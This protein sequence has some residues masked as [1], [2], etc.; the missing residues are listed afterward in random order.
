MEIRQELR[1]FIQE[2]FM[3][4]SGTTEL[5]DTESLLDLGIIDSTGILELVEF[6]E[7]QYSMQVEDH[8]LVPENLDSVENLVNFV[9]KKTS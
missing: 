4:G 2:N 5:S 7:N 8:E 3:L 6:I 9:H 1:S